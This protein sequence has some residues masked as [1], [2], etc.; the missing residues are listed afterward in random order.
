GRN[1]TSQPL[2]LKIAKAD[3]AATAAQNTTAFVKLIVPKTE[4]YVGEP[5]AVEIDLYFQNIDQNSLHMPQLQA[6]G[7]SLGQAPRPAQSRTQVGNAVYNLLIF[8]TSVTAAKTGDLTL[9]LADYNLTLIMQSNQ[10]R[11]DF[12]DPFG[13]FGQA[14]PTTLHCDPQV[15]HVLPLPPQNVPAGFNG[16]V[17]TFTMAVTAGPT[18]LA[19]GD[20]ITLKVQ[21]QGQG[22]LDGVALPPQA[23]WQDFKAY[24][25]TSKVESN[26]PLGLSGVKSFEQV[27]IPQNHELKMLPPFRFSFFDPNQK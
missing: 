26:D 27:I 2:K 13:S 10:R 19:V 5:F 25:P 18:N 8:K 23:D 7:F 21:I 1:L 20:P 16:A 15:L 3:A 11:R 12:F 9:G 22:L 17:G 24:P 6:E 14:V 4:V